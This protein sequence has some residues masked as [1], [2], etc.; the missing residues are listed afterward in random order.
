MGKINTIV[1]KSGGEI[2]EAC[3]IQGGEEK[4]TGL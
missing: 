3:G 1:K 2:D 4:Q